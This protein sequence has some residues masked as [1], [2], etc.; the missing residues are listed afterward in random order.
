MGPWSTARARPGWRALSKA[1]ILLR[2][3]GKRPDGLTLIPWRNCRC[4][5]RDV[6]VTDTL[7][8]SYL[9]VTSRTPGGQR[10]GEGAAERQT[11]KMARHTFS[12]PSPGKP[13]DLI[14]RCISQVSEK[15]IAKASSCFSVR[16]FSF[17]DLIGL[18][19]RGPLPA[20]LL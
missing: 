2:S 11:A 8:P 20:L 16:R 14:N 10:K 17:N 3:V 7:A 15:I 19:F 12:Q 13:L 5:I 1:N 4:V 6:S 18:L 9:R